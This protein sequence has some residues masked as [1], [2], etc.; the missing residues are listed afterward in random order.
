MLSS[1]QVSDSCVAEEPPGGAMS[2]SHFRVGAG[3]A[4]LIPP[5]AAHQMDATA[6]LTTPGLQQGPV[7]SQVGPA[8]STNAKACDQRIRTFVE[9][10]FPPG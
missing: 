2:S 10:T 5:V 6:W 3:P 8:L 4:T 7:S 9:G 1:P